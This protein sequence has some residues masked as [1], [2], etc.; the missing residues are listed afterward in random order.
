MRMMLAWVLVL[1]ASCPIALSAQH[2]AQ[3]CDDPRTQA[4]INAC[5]AQEYERIDRELNRVY[6]QLASRL[7]GDR[8]AKL[9]AAQIAWIKFR[10]AQCELASAEYAGG[11]MYPAVLSGCLTAL[12]K[13]QVDV[14]K[15][16]L[17]DT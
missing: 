1:L 6:W 10:D 11:S 8:L 17:K 12:T 13:A 16:I 14:L 2:A 9:K 4:E 3:S 15:R 5:A 7:K